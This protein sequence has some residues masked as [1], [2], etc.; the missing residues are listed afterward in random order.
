MSG[1][2]LQ[3]AGGGEGRK[4]TPSTDIL[5]PAGVIWW[6]W[7]VLTIGVTGLYFALSSP[8]SDLVYST[9][10]A[11]SVCLIVAGVRFIHPSKAVA[12][13]LIAAGHAMTVLA[14]IVYYLYEPILGSAPPYPS[15]IDAIYL[16]MYPLTV[17]GLLL[18]VRSRSP[19]RDRPA[20]VDALIMATAGA[21]LAWVFLI[22]PYATDAALKLPE[23]IVSMAYPCMDVLLLAVAARLVA[24]AGFRGLSYRMLVS[25][26]VLTLIANAAYGAMILAGSY[27]PGSLI[28]GLWLFAYG[29]VAAA[30]LHP[31]MRRL[32]DVA[33]TTYTKLTRGRLTALAI[34][35]LTAPATLGIQAAMGQPIE[36]PVFVGSCVV[37]FMLVLMRTWGLVREVETKAN[38]LEKQ[39]HALASSLDQRDA[40]E[41]QLK[42]LAFHDALTGV[43]NRALFDDRLQHAVARSNRSKESLAILFLDLDGFKSVNDELGHAAGDAVL[44]EVARR[45]QRCLRST[46]TLARFGGDEFAILIEGDGAGDPTAGKLRMEMAIGEPFVVGPEAVQIGA[47]IGIAVSPSGGTDAVEL[48][49]AADAAMYE[50]KDPRRTRV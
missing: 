49:A 50:A 9:V 7:L 20:L 8:W 47:S 40:L 38:H 46:D 39:G 5:G 3:G 16:A 14:D 2:E 10:G 26:F 28:D 43:A 6:L 36:A 13:Y 12:W 48:L 19:G 33:S 21:L 27:N 1:L 25:S 37:L 31:S 41:N 44:V 18:L 29:L 15:F 34:A 35:S 11:L 42:H 45:L 24:G 32:S 17:A 4:K 23:K 22:A 30:A